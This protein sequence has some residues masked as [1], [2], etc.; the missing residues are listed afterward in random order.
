MKTT[1]LKTI[2]STMLAILLLTVFT[3]ISVYAQ[4]TDALQTISVIQNE[5]G[6]EGSWN[7]MVTI[8]SCQTGAALSTFPAMQTYMFGGTMQDSSA[9]A[10]RSTGHGVWSHQTDRQYYSVFHYFNFAPDGTFAGTLKAKQQNTLSRSGDSFTT[11]ATI[12]VFDPAGNLV[13]NG[14]ATAVS[15]RF[16]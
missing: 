6:I 4:K 14:C 13:A 8:R 5:R 3:Q 7:S 2:R 15:T 9:D 1:N 12:E 16:E 11:A 10:R